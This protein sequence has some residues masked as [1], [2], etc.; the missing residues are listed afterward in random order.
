MIGPFAALIAIYLGAAG[1]RFVWKGAFLLAVAGVAIGVAATLSDAN[2][3]H[4]QGFSFAVTPD[5][6]VSGLVLQAAFMLAFYRLAALA[7]WSALEL[8]VHR[9]KTLTPD[10]EV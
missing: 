6:L 5:S 9:R 2:D 4:A 8:T 1:P 3:A 10:D 7:R